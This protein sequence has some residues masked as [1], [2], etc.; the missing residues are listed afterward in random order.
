MAEYASGIRK[1]NSIEAGLQ[2]LKDYDH[3]PAV[4][5]EITTTLNALKTIITN[6]KLSNSTTP[7]YGLI[8][9]LLCPTSLMQLST[10]F[11]K[12][13]RLIHLHKQ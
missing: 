4:N 1:I 6:L 10:L 3:S 12:Y 5:G 9:P 7:Q 13:P 8:S 2:R 11:M